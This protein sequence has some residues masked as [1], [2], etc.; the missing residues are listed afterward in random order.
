MK[1]FI[2]KLI[3]VICSIHSGKYAGRFLAFLNYCKRSIIETPG[4]FPF[5]IYKRMDMNEI[6]PNIEFSDE[7]IIEP[8]N[9]IKVRILYPGGDSWN[10][11]HTLYE[12]FL[13]DDRYQT[14]VIVPTFKKFVDIMLDNNCK[15]VTLSNY[16]VKLDNPDIFI[17]TYYSTSDDCLNFPGCRQYI[18][19]L[20]ASIEN[21]V[22]N[23]KNTEIHWDYISRAYKYLNPDYYLVDRLVYNGL[24]GYVPD[25]KLVEMG[26]PQFDEIY[27][28]VGRHHPTPSGW[29]KLLGKKKV[30]LWA[31]DHGI[32]ESYPTNGFTVDLYLKDFLDF[33]ASHK[34]LGLIFRPH[35]QFIREMA[36]KHVFWN[37]YDLQMFRSYCDNSDNIVFD[38]TYDYCCAYDKC[39]ALL[40]DLNCSITCS[41]LTTG[42]PICR[43][44]RTDIDEWIISPE[45][46]SCYYFAKGFSEIEQFIFMIM[47]GHDSKEQERRIALSKAV[48]HFD[49]NNGERMKEFISDRFAHL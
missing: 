39:D 40:V 35:P 16:D 36:I 14:Y 47:E 43:L 48:L 44:M 17:A 4:T 15:Y 42:K 45:L 29:E 6:L 20:V 10:N 12:A 27:R 22:M 41:F 33:F 23:E 21:A 37:E 9:R 13:S 31:T 32:N 7:S 30:F 28:E 49:G 1:K 25:D 5:N 24:K 18:K 19:F 26:N 46:E 8:T 3:Q 11:I 2:K 38:E 34:E